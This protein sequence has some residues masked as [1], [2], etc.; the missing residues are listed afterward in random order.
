M[1]LVVMDT[2]SNNDK[3]PMKMK[4]SS[5]SS[6]FGADQ[7]V[8]IKREKSTSNGSSS[9]NSDRKER[10]LEG[11][12]VDSSNQNKGGKSSSPNKPSSP[13][14]RLELISFNNL[15]AP[16]TTATIRSSAMDTNPNATSSSNKKIEDDQLVSAKAEMSEV[17]QENERLKTTL[18]KVVKDY[19]SLQMH[20]FDIVQK[21]QTKQKST[22]TTAV[23]VQPASTHHKETD[24]EPELISLS[25][26]RSNSVELKKFKDEKT[27]ST[28]SKSKDGTGN[29]EDDLNKGLALGLGCKFEVSNHA[30]RAELVRS[31][32]PENSFEE[33]KEEEVV[34]E[35]WPPSKILKTVRSGDDEL[36]QQNQ[37]KKAR[38]SVRARCD[39]PTM[40][41]GCQWRKYGQKIA[42]GNPC[43]RAYYRC[44]VAPA[45]PVRKQVQRCAENMSILI[46]TYE[47]THNHPL[48]I[49]AT[50]MASTTSAAACMLLSGSTS[51]RPNFGSATTGTSGDLNG[52]SFNISDNSRS[53]PFYIPNSSISSSPSYPTITLDLTAPPALSSSTSASAASQFSRLSSNFPSTRYPSTSLNFSSGSESSTI[54]TSWGNGYLSYGNQPY[55]KN[56]LG[57]LNLG[58]QPQENF[59]QPYFQKNTPPP[60][61]QNMTESIAAATKAITSDPSFRSA[62]AAAITSIVNGGGANGNQAGGENVGQNLKWE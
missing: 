24:E 17:K 19:Q 34:G 56:Q 32:S 49:A 35:Q 4:R 28:S 37:V 10:Q 38:V 43:P 62:L 1:T 48:P 23:V 7:G 54:P 12:V 44:T 50:A 47:G 52:L 18:S 30:A 14:Q 11:G 40:N 26:G 25:L 29:H 39:T 5:P 46:T 57:S 36:T 15:Q 3:N 41:D 6:G 16:K 22:D 33:P 45:C 31:Q 13:N 42:K 59:Y 27:N 60:P 20:F 51:S 55:N 21:E 53:R 9:N 8:A 58:R 2:S 61:Q